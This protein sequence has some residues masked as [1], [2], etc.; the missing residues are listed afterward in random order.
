MKAAILKLVNLAG[1]IGLYRF[2]CP[3]RLPVF[4]LHRVA[5]DNKGVA[6]AMSADT[7][8]RYLAYLKSRHYHVVSMDE[9]RH[10]LSEGRPIP[11]R[12]VMFTIDDGFRDHNDVAA[13]VFDEFGY[14]LNFF[15]ITGLLDRTL[16]PWDD[17]VSYALTE[18]RQQRIDIFLPS[19]DLFHIDFSQQPLRQIT[20]DLRNALKAQPQE[21]LYDWLKT[22]LYLKLSVSCPSEIPYEYRPMTWDDAR[23]LRARGHGVYPHT[24]SHRILSSL[25]ATEK[26]GEIRQSLER[27]RAE[28][29]YHA[30]VFAYPTGRQVDYDNTDIEILQKAGIKLAFNTVPDYVNASQSLF[31]LSRFSLP[32]TKDDF[33]QIV[34]RFEALKTKMHRQP[35][36][37][38]SFFPRR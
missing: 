33:L 32:E 28:L 6:G 13:R 29:H 34:N 8:R 5:E 31:E 11:S 16:W 37:P 24:Y 36:P 25:G 35:E 26:E 22:E 15:V 30:D 18:T 20:R 1:E 4:M 19:G 3:G 17:Q 21:R 7:L 23:A 14:C 12:S 10:M 38:L 2:L 27:V 9:L